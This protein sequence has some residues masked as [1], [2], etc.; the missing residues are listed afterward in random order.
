MVVIMV[1]GGGGLSMVRRESVDRVGMIEGIATL[2]SWGR[3]TRYSSPGP[4]V[5][6][7]GF[8]IWQGAGTGTGRGWI[9]EGEEREEAVEGFMHG[10]AGSGIVYLVLSILETVKA[11]SAKVGARRES[12]K[13]LIFHE[14]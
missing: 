1:R 13:V 6:N 12:A 2:V 8:L 11:A 10:V 5:I 4:P 14:W 3:F 7:L 9:L